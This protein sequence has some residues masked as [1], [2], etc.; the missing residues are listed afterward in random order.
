MINEGRLLSQHGFARVN[1]WITM[2]L[3]TLLIV[4]G[5]VQVVFL[6]ALGRSSD[7]GLYVITLTAIF[8]IGLGIALFIFRHIL[9]PKQ[10]YQLHENGILAINEREHKNRFIPFERITEIYRFRTGKYS[11]K[12]L[13][14]MAFREGNSPH[15]H[16]ITPNIAHAERL[17]EVIKNEQLMTKGPQAL[18]IL[19]NDGS[20][21][22]TYHAAARCGLRHLFA[23]NLMGLNEKK[24]RLSARFLTSDDGICIPVEEIQYISG[25]SNSQMIHLMDGNRRILFS[26]LYTSLFNAD[27]FIALIEHMIQNRIP[28]RN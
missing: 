28:I 12:I 2:V 4:G 27:L 5:A 18:N 23:N 13:N 6:L 11:R 20:V 15:W 10:T 7:G 24:L 3:A 16:K 14:T 8:S 21:V 22:F 17:V 1:S 19:A 9:K 26:V 25:G